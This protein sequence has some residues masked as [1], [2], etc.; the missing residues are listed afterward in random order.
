MIISL[1]T[2]LIFILLT[3][4]RATQLLLAVVVVKLA[5]ILFTFVQVYAAQFYLLRFYVYLK[6]ENLKVVMEVMSML[7]D[8]KSRTL[9]ANHLCR[10]YISS[11]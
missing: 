4:L 6:D 5:C 3:A 11:L 10:Q 9:K 7:I 1:I 2:L 8:L